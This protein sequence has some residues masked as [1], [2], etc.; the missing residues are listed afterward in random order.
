MCQCPGC[1]REEAGALPSGFPI[2]EP[3]LEVSHLTSSDLR[4]LEAGVTFLAAE[5]EPTAW[6]M[7]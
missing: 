2:A 3:P 1:Q 7:G 6:E 5:I 4:L